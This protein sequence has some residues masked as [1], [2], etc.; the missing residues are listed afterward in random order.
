MNLH[1]LIALQKNAKVHIWNLCETSDLSS[2]RVVGWWRLL[3]FK[4]FYT[5]LIPHGGTW[6]WILPVSI[7]PDTIWLSEKLFR[8][9]NLW[10]ADSYVLLQNEYKF[11][12]TSFSSSSDQYGADKPGH[13]PWAAG[14]EEGLWHITIWALITGCMQLTSMHV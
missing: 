7:Q 2:I 13:L 10:P 3:C 5:W 4:I 8:R 1:W 11:P 9:T 6:S 12:Q 14:H